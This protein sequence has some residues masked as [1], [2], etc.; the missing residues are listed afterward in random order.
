RGTVHRLVQQTLHARQADSVDTLRALEVARLDALQQALWEPALTGDLR[1]VG[2][3]V[4][5]VAARSR[6][7]GLMPLAKK[8]G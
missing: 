6:L 3:V 2:Q 7:L 8:A 5:I 4:Q 1:A